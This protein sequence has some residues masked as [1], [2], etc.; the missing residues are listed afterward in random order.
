MRHDDPINDSAKPADGINSLWTGLQS[1]IVRNMIEGICLVKE[2]DG[3]I[4]YANPKFAKMF[5]YEQG[6]LE[7]RH[8]SI[9]NFGTTPADAMAVAEEIM[10]E[11]RQRDHHSY[12]VH[13]V[14]KDGTL[15]WSRATTSLFDHPEYGR[16]F[17]AVQEDITARKEQELELA[18]SE[19]RYRLL[20]E[21]AYDSIL[22]CDGEGKILM[23]NRQL[24][25]KFGYAVSELVGQPVEILIPE[26]FRSSHALFHTS[27]S[28]NLRGRPMGTG[29]QLCGR[30]KDGSEFPV[31]ISLSPTQL[32]E[33][34]QVIS[35]IRDMTEQMRHENQQSILAEMATALSDTMDF[36]QRLQRMADIVVPQLADICVVRLLENGRLT[37]NAA[38]SA[39]PGLTG[40][41]RRAVSHGMG[42]QGEFGAESV[43]RT[44]K[45]VYV[46]DTRNL[47]RNSSSDEL[48]RDYVR[49]LGATTYVILPLIASGQVI[50]TLTLSHSAPGKSFSAED[51][52]FAEVVAGRYA[53]AVENAKLYRAATIEKENA[54]AAVRIREEVLAV[55]SHDLK[56]P[57]ASIDMAANLLERGI[58]GTERIQEYT[59]R[60]RR[61]VSQAM[62]LINGLLDF[63]K[64]QSGTFTLQKFRENAGEVIL[65]ALEQHQ[66]LAEAK[67]ITLERHLSADLGSFPCDSTRINQVLSNLIGNA[68][69]FTPRGGT[70]RVEALETDSAIEITVADTGYGIPPELLPK[71][72][73]RYWQAEATKQFGTGLGLAIA[74]GIVEAHGGQ[75]WVESEA[76][77]GSRFTFTIPTE[78][79]C[80]IPATRIAENQIHAQ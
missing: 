38:A 37:Y 72:F 17:V 51:L 55:V 34:I 39:V 70:I 13:N 15:F 12:E 49:I 20:F 78:R 3:T 79:V 5:G 59:G 24:A 18:A 69:K 60:I 50:G 77:K 27:G 14:K 36:D 40:A 29:R 11:I 67:G 44:G 76:G 52:A 16:V 74:K 35:I 66:L 48:L 45:M 23:A 9:L 68:I 2:S 31:D 25:D 7:G 33:G 64:I 53:V 1:T 26:R 62:A 56:N 22:V 71:V 65:P 10:R 28:Q 4:A 75:I 58:V 43:I 21:S 32:P 42:I 41:L 46:A 61:S 30:K 63:A 47:P 73:D 54:Q 8:V 57:L 19:R 6:E 80:A